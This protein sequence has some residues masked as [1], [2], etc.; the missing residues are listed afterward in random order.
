[1][2]IS[3]RQRSCSPEFPVTRRKSAHAHTVLREAKTIGS[4]GSLLANA[5]AELSIIANALGHA[6]TRMTKR[7]YAHLLDSVV[8]AE[9]QAKLPTFRARSSRKAAA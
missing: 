7:H 6:A 5:G 2:N 8:D 3:Q 1:V 4:Y 9:L